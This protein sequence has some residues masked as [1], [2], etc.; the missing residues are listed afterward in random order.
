MTRE[1]QYKDDQ[2]LEAIAADFLD[3]NFYAIFQGRVPVSR[4]SDEWHQFG[5]VDTSIGKLC[6][7]EKFKIRGLMNQVLQYPSLEV[8]FLNKSGYVQDGW[9]VNDDLSTDYYAY[10]GVSA[11]VDTEEQLTSTSQISAADVLWFKKQEVLDFIQEQTTIE[12][13]KKDAADLRYDSY[14][15][16]HGFKQRK[17]YLHH[18]FWLTFSKG[19]PEQPINLVLPRQTLER[20]PSSK[21]FIVYTDKKVRKI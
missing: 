12:E 19:L 6:F 9:F 5:G 17:T 7:D 1:Q 14:D 2:R 15:Y 11:S 18:K 21:H 10:I 3:T 4:F 8:S 20:L 16:T 13:L